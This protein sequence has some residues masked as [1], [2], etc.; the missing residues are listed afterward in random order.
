MAPERVTPMFPEVPTFEEQGY[1]WSIGGWRALG[2][3]RDT[4]EEVRRVLA[5]G[6]GSQ[7]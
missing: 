5:Y 3:P 2:V 4:P 1:D 6:R 7:Y